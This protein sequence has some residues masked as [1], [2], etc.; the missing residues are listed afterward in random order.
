MIY[1]IHPEW[2]F[3]CRQ[4]REGTTESQS[5]CAYQMSASGLYDL[6]ENNKIMKSTQN[7]TTIYEL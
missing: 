4:G 3:L 1:I 5:Q 2:L 6:L 7:S